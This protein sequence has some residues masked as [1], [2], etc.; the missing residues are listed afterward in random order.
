MM[1]PVAG[2]GWTWF[3]ACGC[4]ADLKEQ[5]AGAIPPGECIFGVYHYSTLLIVEHR[6]EE[7]PVPRPGDGLFCFGGGGE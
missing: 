2:D 1:E 6:R 5:L 3:P 7:N 4:R